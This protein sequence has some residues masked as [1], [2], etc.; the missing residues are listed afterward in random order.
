MATDGDSLIGED[1]SME[2]TRRRKTERE[3]EVEMDDEYILNLQS[4]Y[5]N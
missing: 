5:A 1:G 3:L 2:V 4:K